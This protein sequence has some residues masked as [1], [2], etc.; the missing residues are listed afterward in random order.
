MPHITALELHRFGTTYPGDALAYRLERLERSFYP[1]SP[2]MTQAAPV[3][4]VRRL[5]TMLPY[6]SWSADLIAE[7]NAWR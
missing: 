1:T 3:Q 6:A 2:P 4:R 5:I 7:E